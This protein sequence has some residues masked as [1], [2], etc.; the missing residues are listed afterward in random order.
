MPAN[1]RPISQELAKVAKEELNEVPERIQKD[2]EALREWIRK[3]PH[4]R[5]RTDDQFLIAFL[6]GC[7]WSLERAK[8]KIEDFY[9]LRGR[10]PE[11]VKERDPLN[12]KTRELIRCGVALPLPA[13]ETP[14]S[15]RIMLIRPGA[16]N[17]E[18]FTFTEV[19]KVGNMVS[20]FVMLNDDNT[21]IAGQ[22]D[23][24][25]LGNVTAGH[26]LQM[27]PG[28]VR[29]ITLLTQKGLPMRQLE[30]H[31]IN[32]PP[33]FE[34]LFN[35]FKG[36]VSE[37]QRNRIHVHGSNIEQLYRYI[38]KRLFPDEYGGEA[39]KIEEIIDSWEQKLTSYAD[40]FREDED[41]YGAI[42]QE[43]LNEVPERIEKD[44]QV[45]KDWLAKQPHL[46]SRTEDQFLV[47]FLRNFRYSLEKAKE[48]IDSYYSVRT[49]IPEMRKDRDPL[50][51]KNREIVQTGY[52][53]YLPKCAPGGPRI[54]LNRVSAFDPNKYSIYELMKVASMINDIA[55]MED[56]NA[57]ISGHID[58][59][60]LKDLTM[61]HYS[62]F[63]PTVL[64]KLIMIAQQATPLH[65][66][67]IHYLHLPATMNTL[68]NVFKKYLTEKNGVKI[69]VHNN[70]ESLQ[71]AIS[72]EFLPAEYGGQG[73]TI[74]EIAANWE[75]KLLEKREWF[76]D[77]EKY[78][79]DEK[80]R[81]GPPRTAETICKMAKVRELSP[82]LA[83][84]AKEELN[85]VPERIEKDL[86]ALKEWIQKQP[87][88]RARTDDQFLVGFLRGCKWS[89][90]RT[91]E[92]IDSYYTARTVVDEVMSPR[93]PLL[94]K[95]LTVLR[96]GY[97]VPLPRTESPDSPRVVLI[98]YGCYD[99]DEYSI[100]DV[101]R[102]SVMIAD[103]MHLEDDNRMCAGEMVLVD[104]ENTTMK[105]LFQV[106]PMLMKKFAMLTH[107]AAPIR[108]KGFHF[109]NTA[110]GF[111][112]AFG[113]FRNFM[114][115]K[116]RERWQVH[117]GGAEAIAKVVPRHILPKEYGGDAGSV[118][119]I[120]AEW[121]KKLIA[122]RDYLI[123][124]NNYGVDEDKRANGTAKETK[125]MPNIRAIS[126]ELAKLAREE[127]NEVPERIDADLEALREW[128][129]KQPHLHART[130]DQF[131]VTFFRGCKWSLERTKQKLDTFYTVRSALPELISHRD[132]LERR[133]L[134]VIR[135]G[136]VVPLPM[137]EKPDGPRIMLFRPGVYNPTL[138]T[139]HEMIKV[140]L[141][142]N[143]ILLCR[144]DNRTIA[145]QVGI[146]DLAG[147]TMA[148]L[149]QANV[150]LMKKFSMI[151]QDASPLRQKGF[152]FVN[153]PSGFATIYN[154]AKGM[155]N[156]KMQQRFR[157]HSD[158]E[159]LFQFIPKRMLPTE[160]GGDAGP[161]QKIIDSVEKDLT[162]ARDFFR[163]ED[164]YG[165][166]ERKRIG[167]PKN[168]ETL[169]G[170]EGSFRKLAVD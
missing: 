66:K 18:K 75:K 102:L 131:L 117:G 56:D 133:T 132:P 165:T 67:E 55:I 20:D 17:P 118:K 30:T 51:E 35:M 42:A 77:D 169:F 10:M 103:L 130:D 100:V 63:T 45:L 138:Y 14:G 98:R 156:E 29:K 52:S 28:L 23:I 112:V 54:F 61:A 80:K 46:H 83:K 36:F 44:L 160:Y 72:S 142:V 68:F 73:G 76:L 152:H 39:G 147:A 91:K 167:R 2:L 47:A 110:S 151:T 99:P 163:E 126:P 114:K 157:V 134:E 64:K 153:P 137:T 143:D 127:L 140:S 85:E 81:R 27:N 161:I 97:L 15:P 87:H 82:E 9:T 96:L 12:E 34:T 21:M 95:N 92:K 136:F 168:A 108:Q 37:K 109:F 78:G 38:P 144:D 59:M 145:G 105:H 65:Q 111:E 113:T 74:A 4:L 26:F 90:E 79:T 139:I 31:C 155:F 33:G 22:I 122:N 3:Q 25:D 94:E 104:M 62:V 135:M 162:E 107:E 69:Y 13:T 149:G 43:E 40:W 49:A 48:M 101:I 1:I 119:D 60:D 8:E 24:L 84:L 7:K 41:L 86:E 57:V 148:H 128:I 16:Y 154:L 19:M 170:V 129:R 141:M 146:V 150:V 116:V 89:L 159:S 5:A 93:D 166:N 121:E 71:A 115:E 120:L 58:I 125:E 106:T 88:L 164:A 6:R 32:T 53:L 50:S 158:K 124:E 11:I 70:L 123:D